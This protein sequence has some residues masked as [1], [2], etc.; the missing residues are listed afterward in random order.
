[1]VFG[2]TDAAYLEFSAVANTDDGTC[3]TLV[4]L[5]CTDADFTEFD[6]A[7]NVDDGSCS[8]PVVF[9]CTDDSYLEFNISANTDDGSC[10]TLIVIG[11][12]DPQA[13]NYDFTANI[14]GPCIYP[15]D[16]HGVDYVDCLGNC[17]NDADNDG[18]CDEAE[19]PGCTDP[20]AVNFVEAT[21]E[22]ALASTADASILPR[23]RRRCRRGRR[24][25]STPVVLGCTDAGF[26]E[27]DPAA[28]ADDG[29]CVEAVSLG[30]T[31]PTAC[32][33]S[34]GYNTDD[35]SCI[36]AADIY[37]NDL[38][39]CFGACLND[40]DGDGVCDENEVSGCSDIAA[41][42]YNPV[43]TEDDGSCEYCSCYEP[44]MVAGPSILTF[45]SDSAGYGAK[46][47]R[48][49]EHTTG[50]LAGMSTYRLF[51]TVQDEAD[52]LSSVFGNAQPAEC[53]HHDV[54]VPGPDRIELWHG[55]QPLA[56]QCDSFV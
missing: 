3:V 51:I 20:E 8:T 21:D 56:L 26:I 11:C 34:G 22:D 48:I 52:K 42:N 28:N 15:V 1:M 14:L 46:V 18:I 19:V 40:A 9:G 16:I 30:C 50:D 38:V 33:Y 45:D 32:N 29:S 55:D 31:D 4:V 13:C 6:A 54:L 36:Y 35:G 47:V 44:E 7:A 5:G 12:F 23:V 37:G 43:V 49:A 24:A 2:C 53:Q 27:Y 41:C 10:V 25:C 17:L 39:D